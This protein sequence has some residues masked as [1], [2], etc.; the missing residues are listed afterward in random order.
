MCGPAELNTLCCG[1]WDADWLSN[2][3]RRRHPS[4]SSCF[5]FLIISPISEDLLPQPPAAGWARL[6][7]KPTCKVLV[8][9]SLTHFSTEAALDIQ[10]DKLRL[11]AQAAPVLQICSSSL[12]SLHSPRQATIPS[13]TSSLASSFPNE[14]VVLRERT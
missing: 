4:T 10:G 7:C 12:S 1:I 9:S 2:P 5:G 8:S 11:S 3:A 14:T 6:C 13:F